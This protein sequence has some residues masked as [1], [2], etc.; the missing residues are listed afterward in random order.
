MKNQFSTLS[1]PLHCSIFPAIDYWHF[2]L[3]LK[4]FYLISQRRISTILL[5][6]ANPWWLPSQRRGEREWAPEKKLKTSRRLIQRNP[7]D[8]GRGSSARQV[9]RK[10]TIK[11]KTGQIRGAV[12]NIYLL[13]NMKITFIM[14]HQGELGSHV[15]GTTAERER[16]RGWK[17][18]KLIP[19]AW[20]PR[21]LL[22]FPFFFCSLKTFS[23]SEHVNDEEI[24][25]SIFLLTS[26]KIVS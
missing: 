10:G 16:G 1:S 25:D 9:G 12:R 11:Y 7:Q 5:F 2:Q 8:V 13:F 18:E 19:P 15:G 14:A 26:D 22:T 6:T 3:W 20:T 23:R 24:C 17:I 4:N 21:P